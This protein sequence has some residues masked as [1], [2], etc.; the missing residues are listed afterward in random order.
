MRKGWNNGACLVWN[1]KDWTGTRSQPS[2]AY[3]TLPTEDNDQMLSMFPKD[4]ASNNL[5]NLPQRRLKFDIKDRSPTR[6]R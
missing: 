3:N 5:Q 1:S 4:S 2:N 6:V